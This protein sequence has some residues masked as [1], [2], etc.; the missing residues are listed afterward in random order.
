MG[1]LQDNRPGVGW[2]Q[3]QDDVL[4]QLVEDSAPPEAIADRLKRTVTEI[5]R[6]GDPIGLPFEWYQRISRGR[7]APIRPR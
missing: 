7:A 6:R 3:D 2:N 1:S 4:R 5:R